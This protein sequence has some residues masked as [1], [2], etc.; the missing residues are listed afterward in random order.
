VTRFT[1]LVGCRYPVQ[2]A[3]MA[4][5]V[6][7]PELA[8]SVRDAG[9]LGMVTAGE[10]VPSGCGVNFLVPFIESVQVVAE[11]T[12]Q[13][14]IIEFFSGPPDPALAAC[15]HDGRALV[16]W[17]VGSAS[18]AVAAQAAGCDYVIA[19]GIEA[20]GHVRGNQPLD[21][22]LAEVLARVSVP[23]IAAGG[24]A[25]P[26]RVAELITAGAD[27]V[28]VGTAFLACPEARTHPDYLANLL[29]ATGADTVLTEWFNQGWPAAPHRVLRGA[30][31]AAQ[32]SG[33]RGVKP[34][35]RDDTRAVSDMAQ[36]AG[37]G[38]GDVTS[39]QSAHRVL[40]HLVSTL[41]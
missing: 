29:T 5:G 35:A 19:Q 18:E 33:W 31:Q 8:A 6:A 22:I 7:G 25:S 27:A 36:Y 39:S 41:G 34:P 17:Q 20:G 40:R 9:G 2:L 16:G 32:R 26:H 3:G 38:V 37:T 28:R 30:L 14:S 10:P 21:V 13:S 24:I 23:V 12:R 15:G 4:G 1:D 11:A